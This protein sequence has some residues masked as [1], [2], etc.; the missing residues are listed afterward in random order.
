MKLEQ[1]YA[2][3]FI[4]DELDL[5]VGHLDGDIQTEVLML[6]RGQQT[7]SVKG[8]TVSIWNFEDH[9]IQ[10]SLEFNKANRGSLRV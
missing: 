1:V 9:I 8:Q 3:V 4:P 2:C 10:D 7:F 5:S 6:H